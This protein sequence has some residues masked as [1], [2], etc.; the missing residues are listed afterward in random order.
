MNECH[1]RSKEFIS[2][3]FEW[4]HLFWFSTFPETSF[5]YGQFQR[6][7]VIKAPATSL[8]HFKVYNV[9]DF[10][11]LAVLGAGSFGKVCIPCI[12]FFDYSCWKIITF[13]AMKTF[14]AFK[15]THTHTEHT[16]GTW[17]M[18]NGKWLCWWS[19]QLNI[20]HWTRSQFSHPK[21]RL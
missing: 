7:G 8:P 4:N 11:F 20:E 6:T 5:T 3:T 21:C 9:D 14:Q 19:P 10:H 2:N 15:N 17:Q 18:E 12:T 1:V 13:S 16:Y